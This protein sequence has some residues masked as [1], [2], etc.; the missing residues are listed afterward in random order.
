MCGIAG[1]VPFNQSNDKKDIE[2]MVDEI[3]HRGPDQRTT[4]QNNIGIFGF[5]RLKIIDL[6]SKSNQPF[7]SK[8][9]K[10]QI[11]YNGEI[12][13]FKD[14]KTTYFKNFHFKSNGDGEVLVH[15][16]EKF[17]IKFLDKIK[18]MFSICIID[19]NL[20][21]VFLIR[22]RFGIK[23]LYF[24]YEKNLK[25]IYFCSEL[26]PLVKTGNY[27]KK[28][29]INEA[30]K[31]F[32]QGLINSNDQTWF[33]NI[34][35]VKASHFIEFSNGNIDE[36]KYYHIENFIDEDK[37]D[38][39]HNEVENFK[40][41]LQSSFKDHNQFDVRAGI[42][43]SGGVDSAVLAAISNYNK[44]KYDS[45][46]FDFEDKKYS[47]LDYA[48]LISKS[49]NLNNYS[50]IL[51]ES[52]IKDYLL[53]VLQREFEPFSSLRVLSQHFLYDTYKDYCKVVLDGS[54]G[55]EIGAG[56][57]YHIIPW[58]LDLQKEKRC[59]KNKNKF[60]RYLNQIKNE[61]ITN[62]QFIKGAFSYMRNP[63][64]AT[65]DGSEYKNNALFNKEFL[66]LDSKLKIFKPFKSHL[67]NSQ[68]ADLFFLKLP[69]S[70]KYADRAS[71]YNSIETRVPFLDHKIVEESLQI[72][73]KH[74]LLLGQQRI[75][76]KYPFRKYVDKKILYLN[77]RT[78]ADPQ[79]KWLKGPLKNI[80]LDL[81]N[82]SSFN[83][84]GIFNKKSII[85]YY[86]N[87]LKY[88]QHFNSYLL[89]QILISELWVS[90]IL[91]N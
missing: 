56:Y 70:L 72:Q 71:M 53:K 14:L 13:N 54:G 12:Y 49:T 60:F 31:Y 69:R 23:P 18:G 78:I 42:H 41:K 64:G 76:M 6:T 24:R 43:L 88:D 89:F 30:H 47:E 74:K 38:T 48:K 15:L 58:Y 50:S 1:I 90:Q 20:N 77:K 80:F 37:K 27:K 35:Q 45:F 82:S 65:I 62:N 66:S 28:I 86:N 26:N 46:T 19:E 5:V 84:L 39:F 36:K 29:N 25:K 91:K 8:N 4:F 57:S 68:Y 67:R 3:I 55:D 16:Y 22:D 61:T 52:K 59:K 75:I 51:K 40:T 32:T 9:K 21:K 63:G 7:F 87:F 33:E 44:K 34:H 2:N 79:S 17:G 11:I 10:I 81:I 73:S 83:S 85:N